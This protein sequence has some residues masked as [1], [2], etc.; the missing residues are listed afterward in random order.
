M[1]AMEGFLESADGSHVDVLSLLREHA[2]HGLDGLGHDQDCHGR[3][4]RPASEAGGR[5]RAAFFVPQGMLA[6]P[7]GE[8]AAHS[9]WDSERQRRSRFGRQAFRRGR[10]GPGLAKHKGAWLARLA[11]IRTAGEL[12]ADKLTRF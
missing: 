2:L 7:T 12:E 1:A 5:R 6:T 11:L 10:E 8:K 9:R 4:R 3:S